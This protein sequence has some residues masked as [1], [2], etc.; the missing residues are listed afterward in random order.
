MFQTVMLKDNEESLEHNLKILRQ[1]EIFKDLSEEVLQ[2]ICD[3][4]TVVRVKWF[5]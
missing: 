5:Q 4:I 1:I 2:K 3:L